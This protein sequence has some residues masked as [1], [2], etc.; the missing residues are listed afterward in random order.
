MPVRD[1]LQPKHVSRSR[2]L[3]LI[4]GAALFVAISASAQ[5]TPRNL[6][7]TVTDRHRE[8]LSGAIVQ[9][10]DEATDA[11]I[12]YITPRT[13]RYTFLRLSS[14]DDYTVF[15]TYRGLHSKTRRL[16]KFDSQTTRD[17]R[18]VIRSR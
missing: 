1:S 18:L 15:A 10:H 13:G 8:P 6:T 11:V 5:P 7:G 3:G 4:L 17:I 2:Y 14:E 9:I 12:S 16:S